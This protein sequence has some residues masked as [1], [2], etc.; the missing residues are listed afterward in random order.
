LLFE[1]EKKL[2]TYYP[3]EYYR[4]VGYKY[5]GNSKGKI[6]PKTAVNI[7]NIKSVGTKV[8]RFNE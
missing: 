3:E 8:E 4:K 6:R 1:S 5:E 7:K 2:K